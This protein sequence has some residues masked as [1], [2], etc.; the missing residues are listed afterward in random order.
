[1]PKATAL[2]GVSPNVS[3]SRREEDTQLTVSMLTQ[4]QPKRQRRSFPK[5]AVLVFPQRPTYAEWADSHRFNAKAGKP[6][7]TDTFEARIYSHLCKLGMATLYASQKAQEEAG[8]IM[9]TQALSDA[10]EA[11]V[12]AQSGV[13]DLSD[14]D[15]DAR[16][17]G[18]LTPG[19][20]SRMSRRAAEFAMEAFNPAKKAALAEAGRK[21]GKAGKPTARFTPEMLLGLEGLSK[22]EQAKELG[23]SVPT[24]SRLRRQL[25][26]GFGDTPQPVEADQA[27]SGFAD[28]PEGDEIAESIA[29]DFYSYIERMQAE[30][31][32]Q[33][34]P[35]LEE[36]LDDLGA[37]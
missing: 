16:D 30:K 10:L 28:T 12:W 9:S 1:M 3:S 31:R 26:S 35:A 14:Y 5:K 32:L 27:A 37:F 25:A 29:T 24:I 2:S 11:H 8:D 6:V 33:A 34:I 21:G 7:A 15:G 23:C 20:I 17:R 4:Q 13:V 36:L 22:A 18:A 19:R